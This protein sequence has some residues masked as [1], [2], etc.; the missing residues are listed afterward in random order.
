MA[1]EH[2]PDFVFRRKARVYFN[3]HQFS[4]LLAA[5][6]CASAVVML[7]T[8]CSEIVWRVLN[9]HSIRRFPLHFPS[10]ASLCAIAFQPDSTSGTRV[11]LCVRF[12]FFYFIVLSWYLDGGGSI[13]IFVRIM[14]RL[15]SEDIAR[16]PFLWLILR[17]TSSPYPEMTL[18][19]CCYLFALSGLCPRKAYG[20]FG[21]ITYRSGCFTFVRLGLPRR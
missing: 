1:H 7:D 17:K 15:M 6:V 14:T 3:L 4:R 2:K 20:A 11:F 16:R 13:E 21:L 5:E 10:R 19:K 9:T 12:T 8:P 18:A